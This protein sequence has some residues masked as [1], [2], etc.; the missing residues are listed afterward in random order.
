MGTVSNA[1]NHP[2]KVSPATL[3][4]IQQAI[5][6]LSFVRNEAAHRLRLGVNRTVGMLVLDVSNPFFTDVAHGVEQGLD[7]TGRALLLA[8]SSQDRARELAHLDAFE[9]QRLSGLLVTPVGRDL[10]RLR[11]LRDHGTH[12][13]L[14][15]RMS[16]APD[17][18][19]VSVEDRLGGAMAAEHLLSIGRRRIAF[20]G[21]PRSIEQV[22]A[23]LAGA[24]RAVEAFGAGEVVFLET[25]AMD[26]ASGRRAAEALLAEPRTKRPDAIFAA[27]DLIAIGALQALT[28]E[29]VALPAD[30]ALIGY[31]DIEFAGAAAIPLT[32]VRQPAIAIGETAVQ[33]LLEEIAAGD[34]RGKAKHVKLMPELIVRTSTV[35]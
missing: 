11:R 34:D 21:G 2:E 3:A 4:R 14:V 8:N 19:S 27:N 26:F 24:Q 35:G 29:G 9:E 25:P 10:A 15:D 31:D 7:G 18:S 23:R 1:L 16:R 5:A 33:I 13:V 28:K 30:V 32:S 6:D 20:I 17:F 12:V 22:R